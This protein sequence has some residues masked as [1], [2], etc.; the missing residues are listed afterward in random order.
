[1]I[2]WK[3][4]NRKRIKHIRSSQRMLA[5]QFAEIRKHL[6][7]AMQG[8]SDPAS[9]QNVVDNFQPD[10]DIIRNAY[11]NIYRQTGLEFAQF[12]YDQLAK[13]KKMQ[14]KDYN[15][16]VRVSVW[17]AKLMEYVDTDCGEL[18][19]ETT[20]AL[21]AG[22]QGNAQKAIKLAAQEGWGAERTA[23]EIIKLQGRM[24]KFR[25][26]RIA[27]TE[28]MRAS[29]EGAM[30]GV[31]DFDIQ[32]KKVWIATSDGRERDT[33]AAMD[34]VSVDMNDMFEVDGEQMKYPGDPNASAENTINCRC[35]V[36]FEPKESLL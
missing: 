6:S 5:R 1:M 26:M 28:V 15:D 9:L 13:S 27:R 20:R 14:K 18:I 10:Q 2:S 23:K 16:D 29:N 34:G 12:N 36:A 19:Q 33:H 17:L 7:D 31:A 35:A 4:I 11:R 24:D 30:E 32:L 3:T 22:I 25:A 21:F 8:Y